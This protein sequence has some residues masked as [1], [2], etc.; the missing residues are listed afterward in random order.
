MVNKIIIIHI[1]AM[2]E[3]L[4]KYKE[5]KGETSNSEGVELVVSESFLEVVTSQLSFEIL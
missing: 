4:M 2:T 1:F 5:Q 3:V